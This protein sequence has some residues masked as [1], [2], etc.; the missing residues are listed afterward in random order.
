[1]VVL[2]L[3]GSFSISRGYI[4][5]LG[6]TIKIS[7]VSINAHSV[8]KAEEE[9]EHLAASVPSDGTSQK[10][11]RLT[12]RTRSVHWGIVWSAVDDSMLLVG[13]L[14]HGV[15]NWEAIKNDQNLGLAGK[16]LPP[17]A[18]KP[19][20]RHLQSR[21]EYLLKVLKEQQIQSELQ[22][23]KKKVKSIK[24]REKS[25]SESSHADQTTSKAVMSP[26]KSSQNVEEPAVKE[27]PHKKERKKKAVKVGK[28]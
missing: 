16:I 23:A 15:G 4:F 28:G 3:R 27:N 20:D 5:C 24:K 1:M 11:Y 25:A 7:N 26:A 13:M 10:N 21:A 2:I 8:L 12:V 6:A 18:G 14:N 9:L 22:E 17:G 19:Q